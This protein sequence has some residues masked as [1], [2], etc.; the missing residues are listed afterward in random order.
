[1][2]SIGGKQETVV[3][4]E[5]WLHHKV[6]V[7]SVANGW[8]GLGSAPMTY[9][10]TKGIRNVGP[11]PEEC[12]SGNWGAVSE[13]DG[14]AL[15]TGS[16]DQMGTSVPVDVGCSANPMKISSA[17]ARQRHQLSTD[18]EIYLWLPL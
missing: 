8:A 6:L 9:Y 2:D 5:L 1:M 14:G 16:M 17:G 15:S 3:Q 7:G 13:Q 11:G 4:A 12:E 10:K 18:V